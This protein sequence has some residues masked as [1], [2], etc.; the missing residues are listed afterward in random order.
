MRHSPGDSDVR[1]G[2][3]VW[4]VDAFVRDSMQPNPRGESRR[5]LAAGR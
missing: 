3:T 1:A 5:R 4:G 2:V